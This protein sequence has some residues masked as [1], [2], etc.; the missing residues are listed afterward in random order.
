VLASKRKDLLSISALD[1]ISKIDNKSSHIDVVVISGDS[2][3]RNVIEISNTRC[4]ISNRKRRRMNVAKKELHSNHMLYPYQASRSASNLLQT[5]NTRCDPYLEVTRHSGEQPCSHV[6]SHFVL[7]REVSCD[8][9]D[10]DDEKLISLPSSPV[11][12][13]HG[14]NETEELIQSD[15]LHSATTLM[16][17]D[18]SAVGDENLVL[19]LE[20]TEVAHVLA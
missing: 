4:S 8:P 6:S 18:D 3:S 14:M 19:C 17:L 2:G 13:L 12:G 5:Q 20:V 11:Q 16:A 7:P 15:H 9:S 10:K 1:N